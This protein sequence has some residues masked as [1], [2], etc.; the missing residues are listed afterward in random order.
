M[1]DT[2]EGYWIESSCWEIMEDPGHYRLPECD[3]KV[4]GGGDG[5]PFLRRAPKAKLDDIQDA[6]S[7]GIELKFVELTS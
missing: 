5:W 6:V 3:E 7:M 4:A 1:D 2:N